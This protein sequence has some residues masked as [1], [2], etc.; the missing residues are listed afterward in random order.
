MLQMKYAMHV[1]KSTLSLVLFTP[2]LVVAGDGRSAGSAA[3]ASVSVGMS[4]PTAQG[5]LPK[6][7]SYLFPIGCYELPKEDAELAKMAQSSINLVRC[8]SSSDLDR[9]DSVG[10]LGWIPVPM[11]SGNSEPLREKIE[12]LMKHPALAIWEGPDEIVHNFTAWSG[13]YRTKGV[14][15]SPDEWSQQTPGAIAY[16]EEQAQQ[17]IPNLRDA[18]QLIRAL[19]PNKRQIWINEAA[20]S[21]LKFVRQYIDH[22]DITGCDIYPIREASRDVAVVGDATERWKKVGRNEKPVWMVL[23]AFSWS[24][25]GEDYG[26]KT[27][28]YPSF[29]ESRFMA[30]D[31]IVHG[32]KGILY[33]GS[34]YLKS[35]EFRQSLYALTGELAALQPFLVAPEYQQGRLSLIEMD[36]ELSE[37][38]VR[39]SVRRADDEWIIILVN[40]G[41]RAHM[42]VESTGLDTLNGRDL[43]LLYGTERVSVI[44]GELIT[45]IK[46]LEVK[47]FATS[48]KWDTGLNR[49]RDF[50]K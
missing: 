14:Y 19:D 11:Q 33:W 29:A 4:S 45:R 49:G 9:V 48:R 25:L 1:I 23:Q 20:Q 26:H 8:Q 32:A 28:T 46:P 40:E 10:M 22:I 12:S 17:I 15:K 47:I 34:H 5:F 2:W 41:N 21:D 50:Q 27:V 7:G 13:L 30:Y 31:A 44:R 38:G 16:S 42:A 24:E 43:Q 3:I 39:M 36:R 35:S 18:A 37:R 6:D